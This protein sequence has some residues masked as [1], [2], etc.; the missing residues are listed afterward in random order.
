MVKSHITPLQARLPAEKQDYRTAV[1][2]LSEKFRVPTC[3]Q[4]IQPFVNHSLSLSDSTQK[5]F[6]GIQC[7]GTNLGKG[8][9]LEAFAGSSP[10]SC[11]EK[12]V[13][14]E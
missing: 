9:L 4:P 13:E 1:K 5:Q 7:N 12:H 14:L 3:E 10:D 6:L 2:L 8:W 11:K